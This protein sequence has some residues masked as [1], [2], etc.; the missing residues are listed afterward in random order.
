M[1]RWGD[2]GDGEMGK[3]GECG[4]CGGKDFF[5]ILPHL[6]PLPHFLLAHCPMPHSLQ[7][8]TLLGEKQFNH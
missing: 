4:E 1:G 8:L 7:H 5:L 3:C 6:P 2:G